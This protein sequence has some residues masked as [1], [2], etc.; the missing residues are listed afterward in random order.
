[1]EA[2]KNGSYDSED[3]EWGI[4]INDEYISVGGSDAHGSIPPEFWDHVEAVTGKK[5]ELRPAY[6]SCS[7]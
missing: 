5:Q 7:C 3:G 1:M 2:I 6:F 4:T